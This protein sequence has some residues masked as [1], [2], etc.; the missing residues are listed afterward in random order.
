MLTKKVLMN[1]FGA[2]I[3][4]YG[5]HYNG[6]QAH[7]WSFSGTINGE[8][9]YVVVQ[10]D[11]HG[12]TSFKLELPRG[13]N[14]NENFA[15]LTYHCYEDDEELE[16]LLNLLGDHFVVRVLPELAKPKERL[17][18]YVITDE[19]YLW[20]ENEKEKLAEQFMQ[21]YG[22]DWESS[23]DEVL[24]KV[25]F[26]V[27][28]MRGKD[29]HGQKRKLVE[30]ASVL[31]EIF[32]RTIGGEWMRKPVRRQEEIIIGNVLFTEAAIRP[33]MVICDGWREGAVSVMEYYMAYLSDYRVWVA[34]QRDEYGSE[35]Q[36]PQ[37]VER[38]NESLLHGRAVE[39][40]IGKKM[41]RAGFVYRGEK[42]QGWV[43][44]KVNG[45]KRETIE[46]REDAWGRK[47]FFAI[48]SI[49]G[50]GIAMY[51]YR[52]FCFYRDELDMRL[53]LNRV[54]DRM[55]EAFRENRRQAAV[56]KLPNFRYHLTEEDEERFR[57]GRT[58]MAKKFR[59]ENG[60]TESSGEEEL[61]ICLAAKLDEMQGVPF[62]QCRNKLL[63]MAAVFGDLL[64]REIGGRWR[65]YEGWRI[66]QLKPGLIDLPGRGIIGIGFVN[67]PLAMVRYWEWEGGRTLLRAYRESKWQ[68][69]K[70]KRI[71]RLGGLESI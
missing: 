8:E 14:E 26:E 23:M 24:G 70:W 28:Q 37:T 42:N 63:G 13:L 4:P 12:G 62:E 43:L 33:L 6:F 45:G 65:E 60:L 2:K 64:I 38:V 40:T 67:L 18:E 53:Q 69:E 71:C 29:F 1:T 11:I 30:L 44:E 31:G 57:M 35:W 22:L 9:Q 25:L 3:A 66:K 15:D 48:H 68:H 27:E 59:K 19:M 20:M 50:G 7:R 34:E 16:S 39:K 21:R 10:R 32:I 46:V 61:L 52:E 41:A 5:F 49:I 55:R 36:P 54:G 47:A 56:R 51:R 58:E 17:P